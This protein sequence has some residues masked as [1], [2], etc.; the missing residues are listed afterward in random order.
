MRHLALLAGTFALLTSSGVA[1]QAPDNTRSSLQERLRAPAATSVQA[2]PQLTTEE[3]AQ[4]N[5]TRTPAQP[6]VG[7]GRS[8]GL[9]I[10]GAALFVAGVIVEGDA[11]T[12]LMVSGAV[13]GA[14][15]IYLHFR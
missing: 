1:A 11:G 12:V 5:S 3:K 13:I 7:R 15:G 10:A 6:G 14:Y 4:L 2:A 9:M 8:V